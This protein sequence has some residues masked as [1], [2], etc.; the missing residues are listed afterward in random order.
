[1]ECIFK[2]EMD[3][4]QR[5]KIVCQLTVDMMK[6]FA[7]RGYVS[8]INAILSAESDIKEGR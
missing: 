8:V 1:M 4:K 6:V 3:T 2:C 7:Y 5:R